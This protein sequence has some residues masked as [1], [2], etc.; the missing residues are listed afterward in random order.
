[1]KQ[2]VRRLEQAALA[3]LVLVLL[4]SML[5]MVPGVSAASPN[6]TLTGYVYN[7][8]DASA[9]GGITV[10]LVSQATGSVYTATTAVGGGFSF[11]T[12]GTS[13]A[14]V[15]GYW[16]LWVPP[17]A[18]AT[19]TGC[20]PCAAIPENQSPT[21]GFLSANDLTP[22]SGYAAEITGVNITSPYTTTLSGTVTDSGGIGVPDANV[23]L[24]DPHYEGFVLANNSTTSTGAYNFKAPPGA[25]VIQATEP[26][27]APN[28][29]NVTAVTVVN[30]TT[31]KNLQ[32]NHYLVS[33]KMQT[34][35]FGPV[36]S[37][38]NATLYDG[39]NQ[40]IYS[41]T[42]APGGYYA[43]STY[44]GNFTS[45][46]Q[47][48]EVALASVGYSTTS[49]PLLV[50][51]GNGIVRNVQ[52]PV[53]KPAQMGVYNTTLDFSG[54][55]VLAG[56]GNLSVNT[57]AR[58]GNDTVLPNMPNGTVG[59]LW[60]QLGLDFD[61][62]I[63]FSKAS[64]PNVYA[65]ANST[66]PFFPAVQAGT[67]INATPFVGPSTGETLASESTTCV[68]TTCGLT[69]TANLTLSWSEKYALNS[70]V[71]KNSSTYSLSFSFR[72]PNS[73]DVYNYTVVLPTGYV[74]KAGET[75]PA[76]TRLVA[77]GTGG[78]WTK[79]TLVSLPSS[80]AGG[81]FSFS[82]VRYASLTAIVNATSTNFAFSSHNV[83]NSTNG[84][85]TVEV[86]QGDNVTWSA[87][88]TI[89]PAGTNGT[90]FTWTFGDGSGTNVTTATT[91]HTYTAVT[92][93][94]PDVGTLTVT[95]SGGGTNRTTFYIWVSDGPVTA[96]VAWNSSAA[97]NRTVDGVPYVF[98]NWSTT[99]QFNATAS[100]A[101]LSPTMP[102]II[103]V[104]SYSLV[105]SGGFKQT[106]NYS[107]S[108]GSSYLSFTNWSVQFLG[109]GYYLSAGT[110]SGHRV[111][112]KGW[113]Y[114]L[115]LT[116][117]SA[118]GQQASQTLVILVND[119]EAPVSAFQLLTPAGKPISGQGI[120]AGSNASA[121]V[122]LNGANATDPHNG[123]I[124]KYYW[125]ITNTADSSVHVGINTTAVKP[126]PSVWLYANTTAY[127]V[128]LT[129]WDQNGNHGYTT[130][131]LTVSVNSTTTPIMSANNFT[132]PSTLTAGTSYTFWVN[133]T[134]GGGSKAV[135]QNVQVTFYTAPS[136]STNKNLIARSPGSVQFFN[137]TSAGVV[138][139]TPEAT[140]VLATLAYNVTVRAVI[141]WTPVIT[142][143][144]ILYANATAS[145]QFNGNSNLPSVI[146]MAITI[147]P[148][149]SSQYLEYAA[150]AAV[151]VV[152][153]LVLVFWVRRRGRATPSRTSGR[154][155]LERGSK[156]ADDEDDDKDSD[157]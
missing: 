138:S 37:S 27:G 96:G 14:L 155:G 42:T 2:L 9:N 20:R 49:Y 46:D 13:G 65:W 87:L 73:Y 131:S 12:S 43:L 105:S 44:P 128:N 28:Y 88:N 118:T 153:I 123:S 74:L 150:V 112:F 35:G 121:R 151:V 6:Y 63:Q 36:A 5:A 54:F 59:Q 101:K 125:L 1:M 149:S 145:N 16:G 80:S 26:G 124:S 41:D 72:H 134:T 83:L 89:Y 86:G 21:F 53:L 98:I 78:S 115:T 11:T 79:F 132:G 117:W 47:S 100:V 99:L 130:Q 51:N 64:L 40:Y 82:I 114:N 92:T 122:L 93:T 10:D 70:T 95:S 56:S 142:G 31:T 104:A 147:S 60:A 91:Y 137:Y 66:G 133:V 19:F 8:H 25:W 129:V 55:N 48:F 23:Q 61:H 7:S 50:T 71:Y 139:S 106:A 111:D 33:G 84:N 38:G 69:S 154:R 113:Q 57:T 116:V 18:N 85:Y 76:N 136:G 110:V 146:S 67:T 109:A 39:Y 52:M 22:G 68:T 90:K 107:I 135:A 127:T 58:L 140:G 144:Y 103:A 126:N 94:Q 120:I 45:G 152:V 156:H 4:A 148:S 81:T 24:I 3:A 141:T 143:N 102:G 157:A 29:T 62:A 119:T 34:T 15:P 77:A 97:A 32:I 108:Q 75:V 17:Q 30:P